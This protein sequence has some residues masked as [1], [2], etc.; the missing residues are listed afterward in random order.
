MALSP[1]EQ[2]DVQQRHRQRSFRA[3]AFVALFWATILLY[4]A[5]ADEQAGTWF[6]LSTAVWAPLIGAGTLAGLIGFGVS[7]RCP[8]CSKSYGKPWITKFCGNC[9]VAL[10]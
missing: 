5:G 4:A 1:A 9:G 10:K 3:S 2:A 7:L 8:S 6:G